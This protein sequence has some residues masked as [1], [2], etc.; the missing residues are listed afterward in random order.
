VEKFVERQN[1]LEQARKARITQLSDQQM[2]PYEPELCQRSVE[3]M[4][5]VAGKQTFDDRN[6]ELL[7]KRIMNHGLKETEQ[8]LGASSFRPEISDHARTLQATDIK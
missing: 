2:W 6:T 1:E 3:I 5:D 7:K 8:A 4:Q